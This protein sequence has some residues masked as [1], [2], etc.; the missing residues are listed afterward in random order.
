MSP[1]I[2]SFLLANSVNEIH[3]LS[4]SG[5][6][7]PVSE[8]A[9]ASAEIASDGEATLRSV[10]SSRGS[11]S[12]LTVTSPKSGSSTFSTAAPRIAASKTSSC[13]RIVTK[14]ESSPNFSSRLIPRH[15]SATSRS[16]RWTISR[17]ADLFRSPLN[18]PKLLDMLFHHSVSAPTESAS[19]RPVLHAKTSELCFFPTTCSYIPIVSFF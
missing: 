13:P 17:C 9:M 16:P 1:A 14:L 15:L 11:S 8:N 2:F 19:T 6:L 5:D 7:H 18:L 4:P 10:A 12:A 3:L